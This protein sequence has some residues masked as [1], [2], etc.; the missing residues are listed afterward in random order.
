MKKTNITT[1]LTALTTGLFLAFGA[2]C[3]GDE[4]TTVDSLVVYPL[5]YCLVSGEP[6]GSMGAPVVV[7]HAGREIKFCCDACLPEFEADPDAF[8]QNLIE[9]AAARD[10]GPGES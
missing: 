6:L 5:D 9:T 3:S 4:T 8:V 2:A 1:M 10:E 7:E